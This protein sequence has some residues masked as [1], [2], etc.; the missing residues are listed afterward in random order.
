MSL[1]DKLENKKSN[2]VKFLGYKSDI[3][4]ALEKG[5]NL[6]EIRETIIENDPDF[7]IPYSTFIRYANNLINENESEKTTNLKKFEDRS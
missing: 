6:S 1:I 7:N 2:K 5:F 4:E 3:E